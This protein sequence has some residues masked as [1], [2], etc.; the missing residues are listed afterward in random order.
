MTTLRMNSVLALAALTLTTCATVPELTVWMPCEDGTYCPAGTQCSPDG[1][2]CL[3]LE[4][5]GDGERTAR[6][7]CDD[8]NRQNGDGCNNDCTLTE[9]ICGN[10]FVSGPEQCDDG[11]DDDRDGCDRNCRSPPGM[12]V[13][14]EG[15]SC[16]DKG[17]K[18]SEPPL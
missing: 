10:C 15:P 17:K 18:P 8:G 13:S 16:R 6:E 5:C 14:D 7:E 4:D 3:L 11:N 12:L 2:S 9:P 1:V